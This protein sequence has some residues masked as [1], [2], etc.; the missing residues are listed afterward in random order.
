MLIMLKGFR[1]GERMSKKNKWKRLGDIPNGSV[2]LT[3]EY[4][5]L[6][7]K[8]EYALRPNEP[9]SPRMSI[10]IGSGEFYAGTNGDDDLVRVIDDELLRAF[11]MMGLLAR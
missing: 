7:V 6:G 1:K 2:F 3:K 10:I 5:S 9:G 8:S 11:V 4:L